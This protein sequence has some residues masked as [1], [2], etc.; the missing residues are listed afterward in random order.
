M[1]RTDKAPQ[2]EFAYLAARHRL[3]SQAGVLENYRTR[4]ATL[5]SAA[6]IATSFL[7]NLAL[8]HGRH[9]HRWDWLAMLC[10]GVSVFA[11][12]RVLLPSRGWEFEQHGKRLIANYVEECERPYEMWR[13]YRNEALHLDMWATANAKRLH[14]IAIALE[15][16]ALFL[17][18]ETLFWVVAVVR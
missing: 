5:I 15:G 2:Y 10:F 12:L 16:S 1:G 13:V 9:L 4:A 7:G 6:A 8:G 18:L 11:A 14:R 17:G 3:D